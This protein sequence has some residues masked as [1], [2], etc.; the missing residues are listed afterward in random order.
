MASCA[1]SEGF[2][3]MLTISEWSLLHVHTLNFE[4]RV[5]FQLEPLL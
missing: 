5:F 1:G 4:I 3:K 2:G